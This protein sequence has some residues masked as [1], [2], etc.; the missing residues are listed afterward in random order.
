VCQAGE[1][2]SLVMD[3]LS[4]SGLDVR[5]DEDCRLAIAW[6]GA[7]CTL[8]VSDCGRAEW[9]YCPGPPADPVLAADL[10]T[11]LLTGRPGPFPRLT[12]TRERATFK[13]SVGRERLCPRQ[14]GPLGRSAQHLPEIRVCVGRLHLPQRPLQPRP[15]LLQVN[16]V[17]GDRA[18]GQPRSGPGQHEAGQH[19]SL[20]C[21]KL[22]RPRRATDLAQVADHPKPHPGP[23]S[24]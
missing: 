17:A 2:L 8:A 24:S 10:A 18:V 5:R 3:G 15:D 11:T 19:V 12:G 14:P 22:L 13:G 21:G 9:E 23:R 16:Y 6:P 1:L 20:E 4:G 7:R